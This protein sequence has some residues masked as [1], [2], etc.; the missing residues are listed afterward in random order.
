[1]SEINIVQ[2]N[3]ALPGMGLTGNFIINVLKMPPARQEKRALFWNLSDWPLICQRMTEHVARGA[4]T[5]MSTLSGER[6][7]PKPRAEES[8]ADP[9]FDDAAPTTLSDEGFF[10]DGA[11]AEEFFG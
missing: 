2:I 9:F 7:L 11:Q 4:A 10:D 1:M 6:P 8:A 5:D 3:A